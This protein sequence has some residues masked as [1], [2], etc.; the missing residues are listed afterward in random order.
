MKKPP[1]Q[2]STFALVFLLA[3]SFATVRAASPS[4]ERQTIDGDIQIGYGLAIG[5]VDED[6]RPDILLADKKEI[7]WYQNPGEAGKAWPKHVIARNL[8]SRD[9]VCLAARDITGDGLVEIA[10]GANW[11]PGNTSDAS[12]SGTSFYLQR[13]SDP[14][15]PWKPVP[16]TPHEPTTHRMHWLR[17]VTDKMQLVVLPLHGVNNKSAKGTDVKISVFEIDQ[18]MP[19]LIEKVDSEMHAT[20]N[21]DLAEDE[22]FGDQEFMLVAGAEGYLAALPSGESIQL[23]STPQSKGAGEVR[24]YPTD[25]RIFVGIEPMH[26]TD[27]V[28]YTMIG[29]SEWEKDVIDATLN[30]GHALAAANLFGSDVPEII[31][32]WRGED[33]Q[34]RTGIK[35]YSRDTDKD[36]WTTHLLDDNEI[37]C[38]DLKAV[39]LNGDGKVDIVGAGRGSKNVVVYWNES[40]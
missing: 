40:E 20:H 29:E 32:G 22:A 6:T 31:A 9:N 33:A 2:F 23:V 11:N 21:F 14:T 4:F 28:M 1:T 13:P 35:I 8:T 16:L 5:R 37:A 39:D 27:V 17:S 7:V 26:G 24:R 36:A 18:G 10:V 15:K 38:E 30:Q 3:G 34:K 12:I 25:E 19:K